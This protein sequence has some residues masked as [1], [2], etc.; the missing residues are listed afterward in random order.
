MEL[1]SLRVGPGALLAR[2]QR[3]PASPFRGAV[4]L[5]GG[6]LVAW[7]AGGVVS[8]FDAAAVLPRPGPGFKRAP[9]A[10][11]EDR[12]AQQGKRHALTRAADGHSGGEG[13]LGI[14]GID[15][16]RV[17]SFDDAGPPGTPGENG[18]SP[19]A[20]PRNVGGAGVTAGAMLG[21]TWVM[22][23]HEG[24]EGVQGVALLP[25]LTYGLSWS[26]GGDRILYWSVR[27]VVM[28]C[29]AGVLVLI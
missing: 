29:P 13:G 22:T 27:Q 1:R 23:D 20:A 24:S 7:D 21:P 2:F 6:A 4:V 17:L 12:D 9:D 8:R 18:G 26:V 19:R 16:V 25:D 5:P 10:G 28:R 3:E 14:D 11:P 15:V